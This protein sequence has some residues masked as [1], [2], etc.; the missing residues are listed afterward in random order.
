MADWRNEFFEARY[1]LSVAER[2]LAVYESYPEKRVLIGVV[3]EG[4]KA[5]G[6][7]VRGFLI[8]DGKKGN[9]RTFARRVGPKYLDDI[10]IE[11]IVKLLEVERAQRVSR[12]EFAKGE[13]IILLIDGEWR[14]L[15]SSRL[16]E[17]V[18]S[19]NSAIGRFPTSIKG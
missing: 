3:R 12:I 11:N 15:R 13:K 9:L 6:K 16:R 5:A 19:V 14:V 8:K 1:H 17:F 4:A 2:M 10:T 7:L 18:D